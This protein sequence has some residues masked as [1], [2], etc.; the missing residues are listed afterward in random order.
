MRFK[1]E[2]KNLEWKRDSNSTPT[3]Q[4]CALPTELFPHF[5][6]FDN[7][8]WKIWAETRLELATPT[9]GKVVLYQ[10]ELFPS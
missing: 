8:K 10:L 3:W 4:G 7:Y 1:A 5:G 6:K 9:F 2:E